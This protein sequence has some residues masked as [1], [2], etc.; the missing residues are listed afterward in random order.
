MTVETLVMTMV[1]VYLVANVMK[2][3]VRFDRIVVF[4]T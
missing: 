1:S 2:E 3:V 4:V